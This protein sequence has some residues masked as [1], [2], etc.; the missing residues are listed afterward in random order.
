MIDTIDDHDREAFEMEIREFTR[1]AF[2]PPLYL[3]GATFMTQP[4]Y[5][6]NR[7]SVFS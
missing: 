1:L 5:L 6:S 4:H 3:W 7:I 2:S